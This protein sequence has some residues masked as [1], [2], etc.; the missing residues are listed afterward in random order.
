MREALQSDQDLA[1]RMLSRAQDE[2]RHPREPRDDGGV[3][4]GQDRRRVND[5][6]VVRA[7]GALEDLAKPRAHQELR[8]I[9]WDQTTSEEM[10]LL[11]NVANGRTQG[12]RPD[13]QV[14]EA[15][16]PRDAECAVQRAVAHVGVDQ[17]DLSAGGGHDLRQ[18]GRDERFPNPGPRSS[19]G[20]HSI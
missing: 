19:E 18:V 17:E 7:A 8:R 2:Q 6:Q 9:R 5:Q 15:G 1:Q 12:D 11:G 4:D 20:D 3:G 14:R 13:D 10:E 16:R